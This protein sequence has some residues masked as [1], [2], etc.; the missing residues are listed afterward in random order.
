MVTE[1]PSQRN[2]ATAAGQL[3]AS[4]R[5]LVWRTLAFLV[6]FSALQ[7]TWQKLSGS[8]LEELVIHTFTVRPAACLVNLFTPLVHAQAVHFSLIAPGGGLNILNGCDGLEALFLLI[9]AFA[10]A[11]APWRLRV[12]GLAAGLPVVFVVNQARILTLFYA[13]RTDHALFDP[14]HAIVA[15]IVV[16]LI[17]AGY[18]YAWLAYCARRVPITA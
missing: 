11:P 15:P 9:S 10:I 8:S 5:L 14:M 12:V 4:P 6:V 2:T 1:N 13:Y 3:P 7:L 16:I 17:V 18:F